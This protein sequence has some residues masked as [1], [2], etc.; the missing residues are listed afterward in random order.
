MSDHYLVFRA[1]GGEWLLAMRHVVEVGL[2]DADDTGAHR[3]W[4]DRVLPVRDMNGQLGGTAAAGTALHQIVVQG[5]D[6]LEVLAVEEIVG[7]QTVA[8]DALVPFA[9]T[10]ARTAACVDRALPRTDGRCALR[11]RWP[12]AG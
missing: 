12:P 1:A 11:L 6:D 4:R 5:A 7:L 9:P 8:A 3:R 10:D 2:P